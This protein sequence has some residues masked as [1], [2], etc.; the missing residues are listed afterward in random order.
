LLY[1]KNFRII[2]F[3]LAI[4]PSIK[5]L[6]IMSKRNKR[7][8]KYQATSSQPTGGQAVSQLANPTIAA[9]SEVAATE[10]TAVKKDMLQT[11]AVNL[12]FLVILVGLYYW[13][14]SAGE[15][16]E[17]LVSKFIKI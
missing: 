7:K 15:P 8:F 10:T 14:K 3:D 1:G 16:L 17:Q 6:K 5:S 12:L 2:S 9:M 4:K 11:I 13:N